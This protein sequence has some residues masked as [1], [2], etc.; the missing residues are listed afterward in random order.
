ERMGLARLREDARFRTFAD[1]L[2]HRDALRPILRAEFLRHTTA[3]WLERLRGQVPIAP[4]YAVEEALADEQVLA[5]EMVIAVDHPRHGRRALR[6]PGGAR[7]RPRTRDHQPDRRQPGRADAHRARHGGTEAPLPPEHPP[8][9]R[10]LVPALLRAR[11]GLRPDR[12][13]HPR[14][15][16]RRRL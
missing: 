9:G 2:A 12:A 11:R 7:R 5:R 6:L 10:A 13:P 3:E 15:A 4:V 14:R 1:R 16:P 8:R